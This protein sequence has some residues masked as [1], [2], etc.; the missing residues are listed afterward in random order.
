VSALQNIFWQRDESL[1]ESVVLPLPDIMAQ[2]IADDLETALEQFMAV[3]EKLN[4][5]VRLEKVM[6]FESL[7]L[8]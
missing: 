2:E 3:A 1:E 7:M 5:S 6:F 4:R 8:C